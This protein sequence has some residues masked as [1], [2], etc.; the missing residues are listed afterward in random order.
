MILK[1][2]RYKNFFS[3]GNSFT[4]IQI[5][6]YDK[7]IISGKNGDGKST[8]LNSITFALFGK[9]IKQVTKSQI[10]NSLNGK[11]CLVEAELT[12][13]NKDYLIKRGIKPNIFEIYENGVLLDQSSVLD[14]QSHLEDNILKFSYKTLLQT[15]IIS[16]ENYLPFMTL[17]KAGR[18]E[19]IEDILDIK[20]FS[21]MNQ[22]I[23]AKVSK[24]KDELRLLEESI[25]G[26]KDK[27]LLQKSHIE[28]LENMRK[29]G[30]DT[31]DKKLEEYQ[32]EI[33][34]ISK[35]FDTQAQIESKFETDKLNLNEVQK[36]RL[37]L[38]QKISSDKNK[39][40]TYEKD[41]NFFDAH[42]DC[43]TCMQ[44]I[45]PVHVERL[46]GNKRVLLADL[47]LSITDTEE[48]YFEYDHYDNDIMTLSKN[49]SKYSGM[50]SVVNSSIQRIKKSIS[51]TLKEKSNL[52]K[53]DD[54]QERKDGMSE[55]AKK[56]ML[57]RERQ[58]V[59]TEEQSYNALMTELF[60]DS[61]IKSKIV[62][63]YIGTINIL[64]NEY[65]EKLEFFVS[66]N[67]DS[68]FNETIKSR[69]RDDF[70]YNSF[71][72]GEKMRI[73]AAL[74]FTFRQI[75]KMKNSFSSN[76]LLLDECFDGSVDSDGIE[77]LINILDSKEFKE[78]NIFVISHSNKDRFA[79]SFDGLY[80]ITKRDGFSVV[81]ENT[82]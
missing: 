36:K 5:D 49:E 9:T 27:I 8:I 10:V 23:K 80:E 48:K 65:L 34:S 53:E 13:N 16:V 66:F 24:N 45:N 1:K 46:I 42:D 20:V 76:L 54:I 52:L 29:V 2:I 18:R 75:A 21:T 14:Y 38:S 15:S 50:I 63:Q 79:E 17:P 32:D 31:L 4:E 37:I 60:K 56:A 57:L 55:T 40:K 44:S 71:S 3:S 35:I 69:H 11:N 73:D 30:I 28:Q 22:L 67:L 68:E 26:A 77:L 72:A 58:L 70:T 47:M 41:I 25:K 51:D 39:L 78:S 59:I 33:L 19:F 62:E 61:G 82:N 81:N 12:V 43:P 6:K 64:V 74:L 7:T